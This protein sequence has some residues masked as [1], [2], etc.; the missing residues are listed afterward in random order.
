MKS[1]NDRYE[2]RLATPQD[3]LQLLNIYE[4]GEYTGNISVLFT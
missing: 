3:A 2:I 4:C 1:R